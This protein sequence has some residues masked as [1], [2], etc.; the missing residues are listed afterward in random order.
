MNIKSSPFSQKTIFIFFLSLVTLVLV[1]TD[2]A[3][4]CAMCKASIESS[5]KMKAY[6][7][8]I[9]KGIL[10]MAAVPYLMIGSIA[11]IWYRSYR[12]FKDNQKL[13]K[14]AKRTKSIKISGYT[15]E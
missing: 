3:A 15:A 2:V 10:Y 7:E 5:D 8:G 9:N 14:D 11:Y 13:K 6:T 12:K 4:Q 1:G